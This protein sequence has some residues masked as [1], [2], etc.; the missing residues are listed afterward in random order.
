MADAGGPW[1]RYQ[2]AAEDGPWTRFASEPD[3]GIDY[4]RPIEQVRADVD[5]LSGKDRERALKQWADTYVAK[6]RKNGGVGMAIDNAVRT[7]A[8]GTFIGPAL[9]EISAATQSGLYALGMGGAPYDEALA[10][11]RAR[12]RAV[13]QDYPVASVAGQIAGGVAGGIGAMRQGGM[14]V[15]GLLAGGPLATVKPAQTMTANMAQGAAAG[16]AYGGAA[17]YMG[18]EG[19]DRLA[20]AE[21]GLKMGALVGG[22]LPPVIQGVTRAA[23]GVADAMSPQLARWRAEADPMLKRMGIA[24]RRPAS[25]SAAAADDGGRMS[26]AN[27]VGADAAAEQIIANQL[28]R[29]NVSATDIAQRNAQ[30]QH[31]R[32]FYSNSF[33]QDANAL[34]D[35]DPS[36]QRLAGSVARQ[37]PE[38]GNIARNVINARQTGLPPSGGLPA[39]SPLPTRPMMAPVGPKDKPAGQF[40][41]T[42]DALKRALLLQDHQFHGHQKTGFQTEKVAVA[43]AREEAKDLYGGAYKAGEN[44]NL[45]PTLKPV[46]ERAQV[47]LIDEPPQVAAQLNS[48]IKTFQRAVVEAGQKSHVERI[49]KVKQF[50]DG[51]IQ[52][53]FESADSRNAYLGGKL[54][55]LKNQ[56][57]DAVDSVPNVGA[58]YR[59]AR[60]AFSS[61]M[62][63]ID[64]LKLGREVFNENADVAVDQIRSLTP[65]QQKMFRLGL[66]ESFDV[67][68]ARRGRHQDVTAMFRT[69]RMQ[70]ILEEAI[71]RTETSTGRVAFGAAFNDR[72]ERFGGYIGNENRMT[73]TRDVV[74]GNSATAERLADDQALNSMQGLL[75]RLRQQPTISGLAMRAAEKALDKLFGFRADTAASVA[76]M[77]FTTDPATRDAVLQNIAARM[78]P[79]RMAQFQALLEQYQQLAIRQGSMQGG[80]FAGR[81]RESGPR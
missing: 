21:Q 51:R 9:D 65:A 10:Y 73:S 32:Q 71:P 30:F 49:D 58:A 42:R 25:L 36:L 15:G 24:E 20:S 1:E 33:A 7:V 6:E 62:E 4:G 19:D 16:A 27:P 52:K 69:P 48:M 5:K 72:P 45:A 11:Q 76:R 70:Q 78:G 41:R 66:L 47:A 46:L 44:V 80:Q 43:R 28:S 56:I 14:T 31:N 37:Q 61:E 3:L 81:R 12:D 40:E 79:S 8:R 35:M 2:T 50:W 53:Y 22:A 74:L 38:A 34:V 68:G 55:E 59:S 39:G 26:A 23:G 18:G 17:G 67:Y 63:M 75:D 64:A 57:L 29:A 60:N 77:L 13:D 54:T